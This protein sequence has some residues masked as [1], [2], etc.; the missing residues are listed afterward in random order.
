MEIPYRKVGDYYIPDLEYKSTEQLSHIG[1]YGIMR[2][3]FLKKCRKAKYSTLLLQDKIGEHIMEIDKAAMEREETIVKQMA[4][5]QSVD[6]ELKARD[7][8]AWVGAMNQIYHSA[9]E[10]IRNELIEV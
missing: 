3:E 5:N 1:K 6:E 2:M 7:Q 10:I 8:L 9:E 4:K